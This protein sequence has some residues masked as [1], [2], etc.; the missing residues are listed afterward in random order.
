M[1]KPLFS[2]VVWHSNIGNSIFGRKFNEIF[3]K[4]REN[5]HNFDELSLFLRI[6]VQFSLHARIIT[7]DIET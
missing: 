7:I 4:N 5:L 2:V 3:K 6:K 1:R